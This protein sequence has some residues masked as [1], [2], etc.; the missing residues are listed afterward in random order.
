MLRPSIEGH[1]H[2]EPL[3]LR[4]V[5]GPQGAPNQGASSQGAPSQGGPARPVNVSFVQQPLAVSSVAHVSL[6]GAP[7]A[8]SVAQKA[9]AG[10]LASLGVNVAAASLSTGS[11]AAPAAAAAGAGGGNA[12]AVSPSVVWSAAERPFVHLL[13][14]QYDGIDVYRQQQRRLLRAW[15]ERQ[16]EQHDEWLV[17]VA[18]PC[19]NQETIAKQIRK[20]TEKIRADFNTKDRIVR[21]PLGSTDPT[22]EGLAEQLWAVRRETQKR[23]REQIHKETAS[24]GS[25][26]YISTYLHIYI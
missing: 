5:G 9:A 25:F 26:R 8:L 6:P 20:Y 16:L 12:A 1:L 15:V 23:D 11:A 24:R 4:G 10:A 17:L 18:A 14:L 19:S 2:L 21:V 3:P 7:A 22:N 13:L